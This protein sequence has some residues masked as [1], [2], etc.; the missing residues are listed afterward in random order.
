M[1]WLR[2]AAVLGVLAALIGIV[3][4]SSR[5]LAN[6]ILQRTERV[7][8]RSIRQSMGFPE[9]RIEAGLDL[10]SGWC[11]VDTTGVETQTEITR[12]GVDK[13]AAVRAWVAEHSDRV[14]QIP[15]PRE[16][17]SVIRLYG[18]DARR[19]RQ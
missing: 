6:Y 10:E 5:T 8:S 16:D 19:T 11:V 7:S 4:R 3:A 12:A 9:D 15:A 18:R 17:L 14:T 1:I 2:W 13:R